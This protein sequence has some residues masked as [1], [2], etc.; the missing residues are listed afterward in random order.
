MTIGWLRSAAQRFTLLT[1]FAAQLAFFLALTVVPLTA[2]TIT[3]VSRALPVDLTTEVEQVLSGLLPDEAHISPADVFRWARSSASTGWLTASF[4]FTVLT[5]FTFMTTCLRAIRAAVSGRDSGGAPWH[6]TVGAAALL[7]VWVVAMIATAL[8]LF[9]A[10]SVERGLLDLPELSDFSLSAF[11]ALRVLLMGAILFGATFFMYRVAPIPRVGAW[12]VALA[13]LGAA[14]GWLVVS[15]G[16]SEMVARLWQGA[17]LYGT[18]GSV[19]LFL[20]W[21]YANAWILLLASLVLIRRSS[22]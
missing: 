11:A 3:L 4:L 15:K 6:F 14:L 16:F 5:S 19:V 10:P 12:R 2:V 22:A 1:G 20:M 13:S 21:A 17:Q 8:L 9:I 7:V 18:L